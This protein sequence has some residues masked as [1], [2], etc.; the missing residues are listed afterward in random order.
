MLE[1]TEKVIHPNLKQNRSV[2]FKNSEL[3]PLNEVWKIVGEKKNSR[4]KISVLLFLLAIWKKQSHL[5]LFYSQCRALQ[6]LI[7]LSKERKKEIGY[8][9]TLFTF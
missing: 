2:E 1:T 4:Q 3:V 9:Q 5:R 8:I 6:P 7:L